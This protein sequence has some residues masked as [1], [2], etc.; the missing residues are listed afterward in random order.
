MVFFVLCASVLFPHILFAH[1]TVWPG[2]KLK[3]LFTHA[4]SFEQKNLYI[5]DEER[6]AI[7]KTLGSALPEEDLKPSVYLAVIRSSPDAP[8]RKG[9][10]IMFIDAYGE[11]GKI[12][13]GVVVGG[14]GELMK[15]RIFENSEPR[16]V[17]QQIFL[18]QFEGKKVTDS[19]RVGQDVFAPSGLEKSAQAI[20]SGARRGLHIISKMFKKK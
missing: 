16:E 13:M 9:A 17:T 2:E 3:A 18:K 20:A 8:A 1:D 5:S 10:A 11:G 6:K 15:V 19:F 14:K 4:E 7:E 12:E